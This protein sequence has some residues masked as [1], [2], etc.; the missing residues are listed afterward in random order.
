MKTMKTFPAFILSFCFALTSIC[1]IPA[2]STA[3]FSSVTNEALVNTT[4]AGDQYVYYW[5]VRTI[6]VQPDGGYISV[7]IDLNGLDGSADGIF[8][9]RFNASGAKVGSQFQVNTTYNGSQYSPAV[10]VAPDG[11]FIV[12]W[13]GPGTSVDVFAQRFTKDGVKIGAEFLFNTTVSGNQKYP[14]LQFYPDGT[15]VAG[16]VDAAQTVLQR[17]DADGRTIGLETRISSGTGDVVLDGLCVRPDKS[18]LLTWTSGQDVYG[19]FFDTNLQPIGTATRMNTYTAGLQEYSIPRVDG[20]GNFVVVWESA[21]QDGSGMSIYGRRYDKNFNPLGGEFAIT[22]NTTNDQ[23]EPQVAMEPGGRFIITWTDNNN[24][25]GGGPAGGWDGTSVWMREYAANGNPVGS[26]TMVNQS[27]TGYQGYPVIDVNAS[28]RFVI[29]FEGNGTQAGQIDNQGVFSR[30]YQLSQTGTT[31]I[32]VTPATATAD[33]IVTVTMTLTASSNITNVTPNSLSLSGT[34]GV[35]ATLISGPSPASATVGTSP[36]SFTWTYRV[37][38]EEA[39]GVLTFGGNAH[40]DGVAIFPYAVSSSISVKPALFINDITAPNLVDDSNNPLAGPKAFTIGAKITNPGLDTLTNV[41]IYLGNGV[42]PGTFHVTS[43]TLAQTNNTYQGSFS[44]TPL[45]GAGDCTRS[46]GSLAPAKN[47]IAGLVDFD[48]NAVIN[49]SDDGILGNGKQVINGRV[50]VTGNGG[51]NNSDDLPRPPGLFSGYREPAIIDGYV[52]ANN[53]GIINASDNSTY[54]GA[55]K[56]VYWQVSYAVKDAYNKPT[57]GDCNDLADDLRYKWAVWGTC[58]E[59]GVTRTD[60]VN[61][62]AKVRCELSAGTNKIL[63]TG[64]PAGYITGSSPHVIAGMVDVNSDGTITN[65]DNGTYYGMRILNGKVD[66]DNN[67]TITTADDGVLS[68]FF[69]IDGYI[70]ANN[71]GTITNADDGIIVQPGM[72]F[73]V[74]IHNATFGSV[75]AGFDENRDNL[76][77]FDFWHQPIGETNWPAASFRLIDIQSDVTGSGG[78]NPLNNVTTHF[79][80]EPYI[81]R[82]I[83]DVTGGF[84]ATYTYTFLVIANGNGYLSPYQ[85]AASGANNI[86]YNGDYGSGINILTIGGGS[87]LPVTGLEVTARLNNNSTT[88]NIEWKTETEM[89][90]DYFTVER[91]IGGSQFT[92]IYSSKAAGYSV[93]RRNYSYADDIMSVKQQ[94]YIYYRIRQVDTDGKFTYSNVVA[95]RLNRQV[96]VE[97]WPNP[98]ISQFSININA[99]TAEKI[100]VSLYDL[101]GRLIRTNTAMLTA[102][103]NKLELNNLENLPSGIYNLSIVSQDGIKNFMLKKTNQ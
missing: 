13:E 11:S 29:A 100:N 14:E 34:N 20:D 87:I 26:E 41:V 73:S 48:G 63:P 27:I 98:F 32:T 10:A 97:A 95:V 65:A 3:Q 81:S 21:G 9:Q 18:V 80:N 55:T 42:T 61:D 57:F 72:T 69:V 35:F 71:S 2:V 90:S 52:D 16:F 92:A 84:D 54:G 75:G 49:S 76:W 45:A 23:I 56:I 51:V 89:N 68:T 67:E 66:M 85:E 47:L 5:S 36:V 93:S 74:T 58:L 94:K 40:S 31:A 15:F 78:S 59:A 44:L 88:A 86:K 79:D 19:Q 83:G 22:T 4:T 96:G 17:F 30:S 33:D 103:V 60:I 1:F 39:T 91:S 25:D 50:D 24:R 46:L 6:A 37:T 70:D 12:A 28:G 43:M 62:Y 8:G 64:N 101:Q 82:I 77:D 102:G 99:R 53:D 7:W 38:A